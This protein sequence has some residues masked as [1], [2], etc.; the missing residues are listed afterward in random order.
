MGR[1]D[2][3]AS[4]I[5]WRRP[6]SAPALSHRTPGFGASH[7]DGEEIGITKVA[8]S[9]ELLIFEA[10]FSKRRCRFVETAKR[11]VHKRVSNSIERENCLAYG[12]DRPQTSRKRVEP[13]PVR[14]IVFQAVAASERGRVAHYNERGIEI[15]IAR[16]K[17]RIDLGQRFFGRCFRPARGELR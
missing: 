4:R 10:E 7:D 12:I 15:Q 14:A 6:T 3:T 9:L 16:S 8:G 11:I 13:A 5:C 2:W 17:V 1:M